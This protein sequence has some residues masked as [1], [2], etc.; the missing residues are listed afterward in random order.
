[1]KNIQL[2]FVTAPGSFLSHI[3]DLIDVFG[4]Y[5]VLHSV[6]LQVTHSEVFYD[7]SHITTYYTTIFHNLRQELAHCWGKDNGKL[8]GDVTVLELQDLLLQKPEG[9]YFISRLTMKTAQL[10]EISVSN[11]PHNSQLNPLWIEKDRKPQLII[12][13]KI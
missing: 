9:R 6:T 11:N 7:P 13:F 5:A 2:Q 10:T 1:M 4:F 12:L 3:L 8:F